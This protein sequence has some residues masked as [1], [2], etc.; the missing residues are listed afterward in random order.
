MRYLLVIFRVFSTNFSK[1]NYEKLHG[2][3]DFERLFFRKNWEPEK[4]NFEVW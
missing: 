4:E 2:R 3:I 1:Y